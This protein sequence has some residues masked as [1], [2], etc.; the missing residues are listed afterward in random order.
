MINLAGAPKN[1][2]CYIFSDKKARVIYIGKAKNLHN[3]VKTYFQNKKLHHVWV[4]NPPHHS[5][6]SEC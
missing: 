6:M 5:Y 2:G 1:S 4:L 3:R